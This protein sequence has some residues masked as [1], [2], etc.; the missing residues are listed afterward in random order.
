MGRCGFLSASFVLLAVLLPGVAVFGQNSLTI[1][2]ALSDD[3]GARTIDVTLDNTD[4]VQGF[5][6]SVGFDTL[7]LSVTNLTVAGTTTQSTGAELVAPQIFE[8]AG[9]WTLGVILDNGAPFDGQTIPAGSH[10]IAKFDNFQAERI[11]VE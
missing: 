10:V 5:F 7:K 4:P 3:L 11:G 2:T 6:L 8:A 9:G 1:G